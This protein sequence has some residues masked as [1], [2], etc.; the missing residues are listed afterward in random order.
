VPARY[1]FTTKGERMKFVNITLLVIGLSLAAKA[2]EQQKG[3]FKAMREQVANSCSQELAVTGCEKGK[4][5]MKC[6]K[7]YYKENR[8][9]AVKI[10]ENCKGAIK[11]IRAIRKEKKSNSSVA[12]AVGENS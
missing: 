11:Q 8:D 12:P 7:K 4:G 10:S 3:E 2:E 9:S 5:M 1:I 6:V